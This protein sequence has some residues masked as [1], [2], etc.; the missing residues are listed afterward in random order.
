MRFHDVHIKVV[1]VHVACLHLGRRS[2]HRAIVKLLRHNHV[3]PLLFVYTMRDHIVHRPN[4]F[5]W[6]LVRV[7]IHQAVICYIGVGLLIGLRRN[8]FAVRIATA[9]CVLDDCLGCEDGIFTASR[10]HINNLGEAGNVLVLLMRYWKL[11]NLH[12]NY[13]SRVGS[14][15]A[16]DSHVYVGLVAVAYV[17]QILVQTRL[18]LLV[19]GY[20]LL[21]RA[22][23]SVFT[24]HYGVRD[25]DSGLIVGL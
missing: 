16:V 15:F 2:L 5:V 8:I 7:Y 13:T 6:T 11:E 25:N 4:Y 12:W 19:I 21:L 24:L 14:S 1:C 9:D 23:S 22:F 17:V 3:C 20:Q 10:Y 18:N